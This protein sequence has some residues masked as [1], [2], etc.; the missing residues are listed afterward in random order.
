M[1]F[2]YNDR[3]TIVTIEIIIW[4][5][6]QL[7]SLF[8]V[9]VPFASSLNSKR[10]VSLSPSKSTQCTADCGIFIQVDKDIVSPWLHCLNLDKRGCI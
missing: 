2:G 4:G 7:P 1:P 3:E 10:R 9:T 6:C 5:V 8:K